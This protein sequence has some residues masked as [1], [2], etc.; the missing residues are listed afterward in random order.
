VTRSFLQS[1]SVEN[2][3]HQMDVPTAGH[4]LPNAILFDFLLNV[5]SPVI[6]TVEECM[7]IYS[8]LTLSAFWDGKRIA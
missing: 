6:K 3:L 8:D 1:I 4:Y 5:Q 7:L 2:V